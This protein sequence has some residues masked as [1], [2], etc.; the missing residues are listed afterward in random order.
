MIFF[1]Q[2]GTELYFICGLLFSTEVAVMESERAVSTHVEQTEHTTAGDVV[3][4]TEDQNPKSSDTSYAIIIKYDDCYLKSYNG[5][6][7]LFQ[8]VSCLCCLCF[9]ILIVKHPIVHVFDLI[10]VAIRVHLMVKWF[11]LEC[12]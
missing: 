7:R 6:L 4:L 9:F 1:T 10:F 11:V 3:Q 12:V 2:Y 8:L 5:I